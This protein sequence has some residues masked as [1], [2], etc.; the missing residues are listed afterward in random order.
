MSQKERERLKIMVGVQ[1]EALTLVQAAELMEV[2]YRQI[3]RVWRR[4]QAEGDAG[5]VHRQRGQTGLRRKP[6][7][8]TAS[9]LR[10]SAVSAVQS[11][12]R[13]DEPVIA[14]FSKSYF[15]VSSKKHFSPGR[16]RDQL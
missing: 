8:T 15:Y 6:L 13:R 16:W 11:P 1:E 4:Y 12:W 9:H 14:A 3:K 5:L 7:V 2:G 10:R